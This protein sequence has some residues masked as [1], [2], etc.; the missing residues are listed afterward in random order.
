[1]KYLA[2]FLLMIS[3]LG[4]ASQTLVD[5]NKVW[6]VVEHFSTG[7]VRTST[8][9]FGGDTVLGPYTYK[10]LFQFV[11]PGATSFGDPPIAVREDTSSKRV[12]FYYQGDQL[13]YD[14]SLD[15]GDIFNTVLNG[16]TLTMT[17]NLVDSIALLNGEKRKRMHFFLPNN[18]V[19]IE[20][21]GSSYG[22]PYVA[23]YNC[24][25]DYYTSLNCFEEDGIMKF[26]NPFYSSCQ[27][28]TVGE[29][30]IPIRP[31][32]RI[33]P[34]PLNEYAMLNMRGG[35][36]TGKWIQILSVDG[37]V[38]RNYPVIYDDELII[39][40]GSLAS[41]I[42]LVRIVFEADGSQLNKHIAIE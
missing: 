13:A 30:D 7:P 12:Y 16:C 20:G 34:N 19:W 32:I 3:S 41:G 37:R 14:F 28:N 29:E 39:E 24:L 25:F 36:A 5:T 9:H 4:A 26:T 2:I 21:I 38:V 27:Y 6:S 8:F 22:M 31:I 33:Y 1:M 18:E 40:R 11:T 35:V 17:V 23:D 15:S 42:Y 10:R